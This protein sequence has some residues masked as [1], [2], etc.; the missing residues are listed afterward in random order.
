V[1]HSAARSAAGR[2]RVDA[3][4]QIPQ[5]CLATPPGPRLPPPPCSTPVR[6]FLADG[7]G[8]LEVG[9]SKRGRTA[10]RRKNHGGGEKLAPVAR[11]CHATVCRTPVRTPVAATG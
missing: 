1:R 9:D 7:D 4:P 6:Q 10:G 5:T 8:G 2:Q 11:W 3:Q